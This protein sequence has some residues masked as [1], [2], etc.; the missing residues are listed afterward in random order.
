MNKYLS[1]EGK[2]RAMIALNEVINTAS[3]EELLL[4]LIEQAAS[5]AVGPKFDKVVETI[6]KEC[7]LEIDRPFVEDLRTLNELRNRIIHDN[8]S[9]EIDIQQVHNNFGLLLYLIYVLGQAAEKYQ[10]P[11]L[12]E[13]GF[14]EDFERQL[15]KCQKD[16]VS[17]S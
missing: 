12:D 10:V 5:T 9:E 17:G 7:K 14:I 2:G 16:E 8:T 4:R 11:C 13:F 1:S 6:I 3:R 15:Q